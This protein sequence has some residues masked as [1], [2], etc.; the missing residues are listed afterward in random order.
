MAKM[1]KARASKE[2]FWNAER[3]KRGWSYDD[4]SEK[5]H[6]PKST[7]A[8]WFSGISAPR[9]DWQI[10]T[11]CNLF[12]VDF[13]TGYNEFYRAERTW[14]AHKTG[15]FWDDIRRKNK[16]SL[17]DLSKITGIHAAS[18]SSYFTGR[19]LPSDAVVDKLCNLFGVPKETGDAEFKSV[20]NNYLNRINA[21]DVTPNNS[22]DIVVEEAPASV[23]EDSYDFWP[24]LV[25]QNTFSYH[26]LSVYLNVPEAKVA[27]YFSGEVVPN[28]NQ[29]RML[30]GLYGGVDI[31]TGS[32]GF[33]ALH[34]HFVNAPSEPI[35]T[36]EPVSS[37]VDIFELI[38]G[39]IPYRSF[40]KIYDMIAN[41]DREAMQLL[42]GKIDYDA[43]NIIQEQLKDWFN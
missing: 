37:D 5:L 27:K 39:K 6:I 4:L 23:A 40:L 24:N 42:Y 32:K 10:Q 2:T 28:F 14:D 1:Y 22:E 16:L 25:K 20:H 9:K 36:D 43:Y 41:R 35:K 30:C 21:Y 8:R 7:L 26:D 15:R 31:K 11:L 12:E 3:I 29:I 33:E 34:N 38:Y 19:T 13:D 17:K 18:L